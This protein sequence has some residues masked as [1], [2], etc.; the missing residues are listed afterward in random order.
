MDD[1]SDDIRQKNEGDATL[2][3]GVGGDKAEG[4]GKQA[5]ITERLGDMETGHREPIKATDEEK[6]TKA[7]GGQRSAGDEEDPVD[8][9]A[10][11]DNGKGSF[12]YDM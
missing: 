3:P 6:D 11:A 4:S 10:A 2:S 7:V 5:K 9:T 12:S 1:T 8:A